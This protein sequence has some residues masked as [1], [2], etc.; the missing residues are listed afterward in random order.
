MTKRGTKQETKLAEMVQRLDKMRRAFHKRERALETAIKAEQKKLR[1]CSHSMT[2]SFRWE[3]DDGYGRQ[4]MNDGLRCLV[5]GKENRWPSL[6]G[7]S[8]EGSWYSPR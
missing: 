7:E 3:H 8:S 6:S 4:S 2:E 1:S 5:C